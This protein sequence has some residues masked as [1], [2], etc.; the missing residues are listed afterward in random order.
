MLTLI[1][2]MHLVKQIFVAA[3]DYKNTGHACIVLLFL[4]QKFPDLQLFYDLHATA[5]SY[6]IV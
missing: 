2:H 6:I 1:V 3:I 5:S 4:Q